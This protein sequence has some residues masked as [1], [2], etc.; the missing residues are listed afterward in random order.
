MLAMADQ[1]GVVN[2]SAPGLAAMAQVGFE[3]VIKALQCFEAPDEYSRSTEFEGRRIQKVD[4]G[5]LILNYQK[6]REI[7][8][9][10]KRREQNRIA[11]QKFRDSRAAGSTVSKSVSKRK[12]NKPQS[13]QAEAEAEAEY[14]KKVPNGTKEKASSE[15]VLLE[16]IEAEVVTSTE[17]EVRQ[18]PWWEFCE[19]FEARMTRDIRLAKGYGAFD[20]AEHEWHNLMSK[21][22]TWGG[23]Q[24]AV[25]AL[26]IGFIDRANA[27]KLKEPEYKLPLR[28]LLKWAESRRTDWQRRKASG[29]KPGMVDVYG[30][31]AK[32][33]DAVRNR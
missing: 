12:Q 18:P 6:Y 23:D 11:Q 2:A 17:L 27:R 30:D 14:K 9:E 7:R 13:A 10:E 3:S 28:V 33:L 25:E 22:A 16:V 19:S 26:V 1:N 8:N 20:P 29:P 32:L 4:G 31:G 15:S 24:D 21:I 5:W